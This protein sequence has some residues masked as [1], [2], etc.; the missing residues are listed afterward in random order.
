MQGVWRDAGHRVIQETEISLEQYLPAE[1][2]CVVK[3]AVD[4]SSGQRVTIFERQ[5]EG[6][7][8]LNGDLKGES[9][10][11][12]VL[13]R[14][15]GDDFIVQEYLEQSEFMKRF[16]SASVNT[17]RLFLYRSVKT[18]KIMIPA[19]IMRVGH[20]EAY[21]DNCHA[22]GVFIGVDAE[23]HLGKYATDQWGRRYPSFNGV[24]FSTSDIQIPNFKQILTF[25]QKVGEKLLHFRIAN[26]DVMIDQNEHPRL[27]EYNLSTMSIWLY[28]MA[29][30]VAYGKYSDE[31]IDYCTRNYD[32]A[33]H[34]LIKY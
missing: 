20:E 2:R 30:G 29:S 16:S 33:R 24:E 27:V 22:G 1:R 7:V 32:K 23:G 8:A 31:I 26:I 21:V 14:Y 19:I 4:T 9:P 13:K 3:P 10:T 11:L 5:K 15:F 34:V 12:T 17:I 6:W 28:Q 18:E 25:A